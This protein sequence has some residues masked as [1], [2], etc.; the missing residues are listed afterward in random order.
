LDATPTLTSVDGALQIAHKAGLSACP[1]LSATHGLPLATL[2]VALGKA[3]R[4]VGVK[5]LR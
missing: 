3:A 5:T 2:D 1:E 4:K